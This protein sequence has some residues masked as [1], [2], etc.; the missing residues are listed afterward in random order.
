MFALNFETVIAF[1]IGALVACLLGWVFS[2]KTKGLFRLLLNTLVGVVALLLLSAFGVAAL[3]VN[4]L[5]AVIVGA[6]GVMGVIAV[7]IIAVFL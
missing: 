6:L 3:P 4:P 1:V 7:W 2:L 5:T